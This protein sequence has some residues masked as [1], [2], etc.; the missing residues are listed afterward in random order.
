MLREA[1]NNQKVIIA[2]LGGL[3]LLSLL[4][5]TGSSSSPDSEAAGRL[6][7]KDKCPPYDLESERNPPT[8]TPTPTVCE[9]GNAEEEI[10]RESAMHRMIAKRNARWSAGLNV[11]PHGWLEIPPV[12][13]CAVRERVGNAG[14]GGKWL[15][16]MHRVPVGRCVMY[17]FGSNYDTTFETEISAEKKCEIH[18]FDPT[19]N[20]PPDSRWTFHKLGIHETKANLSIGPVD[21][22][23]NIVH[24]LGHKHIDILKVDVEGSE[25]KAL[26]E[27]L[28]TPDPGF[29]V[30]QLSIEVHWPPG[31]VK[32]VA[33]FVAA[34]EKKNM[35]AFSWEENPFDLLVTE[36]S[37][38][39]M[40]FVKA[41]V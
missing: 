21:T 11:L 35:Y 32:Q 22:L 16:D 15:C 33:D 4:V 6:A 18:I 3:C 27:W 2:M 38:V 24:A 5:F 25:W 1:T 31:G 29:T 17:S 41:E 40:S 39:N 10:L 30:D 23:L 36:Y 8:P 9:G 34:L 13:S 20:L 37:F 26:A 28:A 19:V 7:D 12:W 14:D